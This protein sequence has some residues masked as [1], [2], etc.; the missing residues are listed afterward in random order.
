MRNADE[1]VNDE[2]DD[3]IKR[4][5]GFPTWRPIETA[6]RDGKHVI[7]YFGPPAAGGFDIGAWRAPNW[8]NNDTPAWF[9]CGR[10]L[11]YGGLEPTHWMPLPDTPALDDAQNAVRVAREATEKE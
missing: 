6:P 2:V 4:A 7:L 5:C 11:N 3:A 8:A 9:C 1:Y 10:L